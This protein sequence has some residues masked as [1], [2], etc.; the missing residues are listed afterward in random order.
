LLNLINEHYFTIVLKYNSVVSNAQS[1]ELAILP[2]EDFDV[3][4]FLFT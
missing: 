4:I 3:K 1:F 2:F